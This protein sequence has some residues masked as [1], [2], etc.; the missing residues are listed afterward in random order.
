MN[1]FF[2]AE[3]HTQS[4]VQLTWP[5]S[6]SDWA[7]LIDEVEAC[8]VHLAEAIALRQNLIIVCTDA[9]AVRSKIETSLHK[10]I[11]FFELPSN[12]TWARDHGGIT[13]VEN[14]VPKLLDF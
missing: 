3:R 14:G 4:A 1:T 6:N 7:Y 12:D 5:H 2:P 13:I 11:S 10:N 8:F 9:Q